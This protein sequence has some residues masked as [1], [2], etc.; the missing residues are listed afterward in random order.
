MPGCTRS[1]VLSNSGAHA[2][3]TT[4]GTHTGTHNDTWH[5]Q[6]LK[7][8]YKMTDKGTDTHTLQ[9]EPCELDFRSAHLSH[10]LALSLPF[11]LWSASL[12]FSHM[13]IQTSLPNSLTQGSLSLSY[14]RHRVIAGLLSRQG[15][16]HSACHS[17]L[18]DYEPPHSLCVQWTR[19]LIHLPSFDVVQKGDFN[20][21]QEGQ[22]RHLKASGP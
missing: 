6:E 17:S 3:H 22:Q 4:T 20:V 16:A 15:L 2:K 19:G 14:C 5:G 13:L 21:H 11:S 9:S 18:T 7:T 10:S 12:S 1:T 8:Q